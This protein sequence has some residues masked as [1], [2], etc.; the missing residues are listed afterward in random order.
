MRGFFSES[1]CG[2]ICGCDRCVLSLADEPGV[3]YG[4][5]LLRSWYGVA[6]AGIVRPIGELQ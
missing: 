5:C 2:S 3:W 1:V 4:A 6:T